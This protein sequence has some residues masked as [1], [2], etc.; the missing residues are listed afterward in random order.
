MRINR[1][2]LATEIMRKDW[3]QTS[4][5]KEAGVSRVTVNSIVSGRKCTDDTGRRIAKA[6]GVDVSE[7][8]EKEG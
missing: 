6:L 8:I 2:K 7:I 3:T 4:L 5:A 1:F